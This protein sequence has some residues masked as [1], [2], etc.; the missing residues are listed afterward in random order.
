MPDCAIMELTERQQRERDEYN[1]R[2]QESHLTEV[3]FEHFEHPRFGPWNPYWYIYDYVRTHYPPPDHTLLSYGCGQ[4]AHALRYAKLG[5]HVSGFDI[6]DGNIGVA[7]QLAEKYGLSERTAF[8]AQPAEKLDYPDESF[9]VLVGENILHHI[10]LEKSVPEMRRIL[11][12]GGCAIFKDS[13]E[14]PFRDRIRRNPPVTWILPI[15]VKNRVRGTQYH[16]TDD[17]RPLNESDFALFRK[18]FPK[19][20]S[21]KFRILS[22]FSSVISNRPALER[23]DYVMF[24]LLPFIRR[25]GDNVVVILHKEPAED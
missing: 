2:V 13:L 21:V 5:Y 3:N 15:G 14:T 25:F 22:M 16:D 7:R 12:P 8:S 18:T 17:E 10:E 4:G 6:S 20:E 23:C 1:E 11:K 19:T 24:K 9:D